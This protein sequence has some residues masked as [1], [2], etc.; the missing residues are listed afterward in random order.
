M[1]GEF[2]DLI[3]DLLGDDAEAAQRVKDHFKPK[4]DARH[5]TR[6]DVEGVAKNAALSAVVV[7]D[8]GAVY[9]L[10]GLD[11]W[12]DDVLGLRVSVSGTFHKRSLSPEP[13]VSEDGS[14]SHGAQGSA[15]VID[16]FEIDVHG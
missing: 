6:V 10:G 4:A 8:N 9:H 12:R 14:V 3:D 1:K 15:S 7:A 13:T 11:A 2:D 16:D 5:G